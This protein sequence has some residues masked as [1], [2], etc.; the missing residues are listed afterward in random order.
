MQVNNIFPC[1]WFNNDAKEFIER[2]QSF[3]D[4]TSILNSNGFIT[5]VK[6][7]GSKIM[8]MNGGPSIQCTPA[9]SLFVYFDQ[10]ELRINDL[11]NTLIDGG[12]ILM[13]LDKYDWSPKYAW[14][15]DKFGINWQLDIENMRSPQKIVPSLLFVND[16]KLMTKEAVS[17]YTNAFDDHRI[18]LEAPYFPGS[19]MPEGSILFT[20]FKLQNFVMNAMSSTMVHDYDFSMGISFVLECDT[21]EQIDYYW[22]Y[23]GKE[24]KYSRCGWLTDKYGISWQVIP[25]ILG[26][27]MSDESLQSEVSEA[28]MKMTKFIIADLPTQ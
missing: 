5:T 9:I 12:K 14:V 19:G 1:I 8:L 20:Q 15:E 3:F 2:Y 28:F 16:K 24:G 6:W 7:S 10:N 23:L 22:D 25:T 21:Q 4:E 26:L 11:Y 27:L 17:F 13:P 18:L